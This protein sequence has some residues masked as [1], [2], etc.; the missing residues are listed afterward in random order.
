LTVKLFAP[1]A[2][3]ATIA[4]PASA[5]APAKVDLQALHALAHAV[6]QAWNAKDVQGMLAAYDSRATLRLGGGPELMGTESIRAHF[7]AA[8]AERADTMRHVTMIEAADLIRPGLALTD[9][10]V[11]VQRRR[12]DGE[13]ETV[14]TFKTLS[15]AALGPDGW[16]LRAVR[17]QP[18]APAA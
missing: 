10:R 14:R 3:V 18:L 15:L 11:A 13:W 9:A 2:I 6:D 12:A 4:A 7:Q 17:A 16:R 5:N 1:F 8:F